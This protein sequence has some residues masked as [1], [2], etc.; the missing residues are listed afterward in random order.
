LLDI[1]FVQTVAAPCFLAMVTQYM[2]LPSDAG[3]K[4]ALSETQP[5]A[6][7]SPSR[8]R[9]TIDGSKISGRLMEM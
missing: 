6:R 1:C 5:D 8:Q 9:L 4:H 3:A 2:P 7:W